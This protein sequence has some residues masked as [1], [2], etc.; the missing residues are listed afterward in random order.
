MRDHANNGYILLIV[1]VLV[2]NKP[3]VQYSPPY[4][5]LDVKKKSMMIV[6]ESNSIINSIIISMVWCTAA[7]YF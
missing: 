3:Y 2:Y 7:Q 6:L 1:I 5:E 4:T